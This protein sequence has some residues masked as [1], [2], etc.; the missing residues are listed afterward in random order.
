MVH[1]YDFE[2]PCV[3]LICIVE[4]A[5][6]HSAKRRVKI[7]VSMVVPE[8]REIDQRNANGEDDEE[9]DVDR[10]NGIPLIVV[11]DCFEV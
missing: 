7:L 3:R 1:V 11:T 6:A 9:D 10:K 2:P 5:E 4:E 8:K